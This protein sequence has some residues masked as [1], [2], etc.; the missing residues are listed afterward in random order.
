MTVGAGPKYFLRPGV[1]A[2]EFVFFLSSGS[3]VVIQRDLFDA[4]VR[5]TNAQ[6]R[7]RGDPSRRFNLVVDRWELD[8]P[9][10]NQTWLNEEFVRRAASA[11]CTL[12]LLSADIRPG[13]LEELEAVL[14]EPTVQLAVLWM[15]PLGGRSKRKLTEL[16]NSNRDN[17]LYE[18]TGAPGSFEATVSM[19]KVIQAAVAELT[20]PK[21][22]EELFY[23]DQ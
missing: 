8:A 18:V 1:P 13:T 11:H 7:L 15:K 14:A 21:R 9:R 2:S 22:Q 23:E 16:L 10:R 3:D 19:L 17:F 4:M 6:F 5:T 12:V 20:N